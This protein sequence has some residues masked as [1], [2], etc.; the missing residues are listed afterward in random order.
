M[1]ITSDTMN[2]IF[3][4]TQND[5]QQIISAS[6]ETFYKP[7]IDRETVKMWLSLPLVLKE[8]ITAK[9]PKLAKNLDKKAELLRKGEVNYG[10]H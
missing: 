2:E 9:N 10:I 8:A 5:I 3:N 7:E 6:K 1:A 4:E